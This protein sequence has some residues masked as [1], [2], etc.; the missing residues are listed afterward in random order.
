MV[1]EGE[2]EENEEGKR[3]KME[4]KKSGHAQITRDWKR[5]KG[6]PAD[7]R[8][9]IVTNKGRLRVSQFLIGH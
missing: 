1:E 4:G 2:R 3:V 9:G 6:G 8:T 7:G 5:G